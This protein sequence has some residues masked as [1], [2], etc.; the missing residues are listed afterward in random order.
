VVNARSQAALKFYQIVKP[1]GALDRTKLYLVHVHND[2]GFRLTSL[3]SG[4]DVFASP[5]VRIWA[6]SPTG[7]TWRQHCNALVHEP[8]TGFLYLALAGAYNPQAALAVVKEVQRSLLWVGRKLQISDT[9]QGSLRYASYEFTPRGSMSMVPVPITVNPC[10]G[11]DAEELSQYATWL[12]RTETQ[13]F[14]EPQTPSARLQV[15][16]RC[17]LAKVQTVSA[18]LLA[19]REHTTPGSAE[20]IHY[21]AVFPMGMEPGATIALLQRALQ[22]VLGSVRNAKSVH[23]LPKESP[24]VNVTALI[25]SLPSPWMQNGGGTLDTALATPVSNNETEVRSMGYEESSTITDVAPPI[26]GVYR[27][28]CD[29]HEHPQPVTGALAAEI[30][31]RA[32]LLVRTGALISW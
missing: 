10:T 25:P 21:Y 27:W 16:L 30:F 19:K 5:V 18:F 15:L 22:G 29:G 3:L 26:Y 1:I 23:L 20:G 12:H 8:K 9:Y 7:S 13:G 24:V 14:T 2:Q 31:A 6:V 28:N 17:P 11:N 4:R 32:R